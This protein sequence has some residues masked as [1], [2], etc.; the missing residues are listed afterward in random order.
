[1]FRRL[2]S[3]WLII[4]LA[5]T[6]LPLGRFDQS[7][8]R[9]EASSVWFARLP[10]AQLLGGLCDP[11]PP[12][13]YLLL[14]LW[15]TAGQAEFWLRLPSLVAAVLA[16]ALTGRV[17]RE[18]GDRHWAWLAALLLALHP[19]QQWYAG[20]ARMYTLAQVLGLLLLWLG[21]RLLSAKQLDRIWWRTA[22]AYGLVG[23]VGLG[24]DYGVLLPFGLVQLVWLGL[25]RPQPRRWLSLQAVV[26]LAAAVVWLNQSQV[27]GLSQSYLPLFIAVQLNQA[28][29]KLTPAGAARLLL[30]TLTGLSLVSLGLVR[31]WFR[32]PGGPRER[33]MFWLVA[34]GGWL[35][36]LLLA[37]LPRAYTVKRQLIVLL[38]YL[39]LVTGYGLARLP[40]PAG[41]IVAGLGLSITLLV[42]PGH[43]REPWR[44]VVADLAQPGNEAAVIWVDELVVPAFDYYWRQQP[45]ENRSSRWTPLFSRRLPALPDVAPQAGGP[46][47]VVTTESIYYD[48]SVLWPAAF[49]RDYGLVETRHREGIGLY[50]YQRR[51]GPASNR[52]TGVAPN[53]VAL[54]GLLLPSP[55]E[56]CHKAAIND[57]QR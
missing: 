24:V 53:Q 51:A 47:W 43:Q 6:A 7:L 31:S 21:W 14:K 15:L 28:G 9:D 18:I 37:A 25:D 5:A 44:S 36:L 8:W 17:G 50:R 41:E 48:L 27:Q 39:A 42:L 13:Y 38:P 12:G 40:R 23:M 19:L 10:L 16:V 3:R 35:A 54:W 30:L 4:L 33:P 26:L 1:M 46:L 55:L 11:H 20:E 52:L 2:Q 22:A 34:I 57:V 45:L 49:Q 29:L 56:P 32:R